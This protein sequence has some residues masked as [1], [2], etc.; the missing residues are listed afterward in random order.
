MAARNVAE[1]KNNPT[2]GILRAIMLR[3]FACALNLVIFVAYY[4]MPWYG[5]DRQTLQNTE[6]ESPAFKT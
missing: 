3:V 4:Y 2:S 1:E 5:K 6:V